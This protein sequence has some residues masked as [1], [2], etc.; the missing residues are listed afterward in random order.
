LHNELKLSSSTRASYY[1]Y[2]DESDIDVLIK[3]INKAV[4]LLVG[5]EH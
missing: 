4:K 1:I 5:F 2:N 3:G